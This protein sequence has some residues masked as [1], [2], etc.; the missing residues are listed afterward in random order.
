M[1]DE[2]DELA[3]GIGTRQ[4]CGQFLKN[5]FAHGELTRMDFI[6]L[7]AEYDALA[8]TKRTQSYSVIS[9]IAGAYRR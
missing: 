5:Q 1:S 6:R 8:A 2:L 4:K 7:V 9:T 3:S